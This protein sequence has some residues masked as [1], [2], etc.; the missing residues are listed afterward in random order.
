METTRL[1]DNTPW[2]VSVFC[3][4]GCDSDRFRQST[5]TVNELTDQVHAGETGRN[6]ESG[7]VSVRSRDVRDCLLFKFKV[8]VQFNAFL[9]TPPSSF[10]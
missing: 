8:T 7:P 4:S 3:W 10:F 5:C 2:L 6:R 1:K 9:S